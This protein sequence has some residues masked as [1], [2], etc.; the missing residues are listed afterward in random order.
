MENFFI[1][2]TITFKGLKFFP[3]LEYAHNFR[4]EPPHRQ[5]HLNPTMERPYPHL[6]HHNDINHPLTETITKH[7]IKYSVLTKPGLRP[8]ASRPILRQQLPGRSYSMGPDESLLPQPPTIDNSHVAIPSFSSRLQ[9]SGH[10]IA[11]LTSSHGRVNYP[12]EDVP[13]LSSS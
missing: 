10:A 1:E 9:R 6:F 12:R 13:Q 2:K 7:P 5:C 3:T 8:F 11:R 4:I